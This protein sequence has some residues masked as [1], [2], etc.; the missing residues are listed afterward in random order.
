MHRTGALLQRHRGG[1]ERR[2]RP[3]EHCHRLAPQRG[4]VD[5]VAGM[6]IE[7]PR[8]PLAQHYRHV[9][10]AVAAEPVGE[11]HLARGLGV[12][13]GANRQVKTEMPVGRLDAVE[14]GAVAYR[15][16]EEMP[17]PGEVFGPVE[18]RDAHDPVI[19]LASMARLVP[20]LEPQPRQSHLRSRQVL[21]GAQHVHPRRI[22]P[23]AGPVLI[24][25]LVDHRDPA[26]PGPAQ[27]KGQGAAALPAAD[28]RDV[29]V[30]PLPIRHPVR[31]IGT[32]QPQGGERVEIVVGHVV[33]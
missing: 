4:E 24:R 20:R 29:V 13:R 33:P 7:A 30:Y 8:Q 26:D 18:A 1:I 5:I 27:R 9:G 32:N 22:G 3:A 6:G 21:R 25:R 12:R 11:D 15:N 10:S 31:R 16:A 2:G 28:D 17:E 19:G 14:P 23:D